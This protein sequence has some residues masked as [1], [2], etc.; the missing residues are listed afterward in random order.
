MIPKEMKYN[1][2]YDDVRGNILR[3]PHGT[4]PA[5]SKSYTSYYTHQWTGE[6]FL[7]FS[8]S[9]FLVCAPI[10]W[11]KLSYEENMGN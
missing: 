1:L 4:T 10:L 5:T 2:H 8:L 11:F 9:A 3:P 7:I 6:V